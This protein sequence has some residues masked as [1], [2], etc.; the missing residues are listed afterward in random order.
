MP[1]KKGVAA[2]RRTLDYLNSGRL[3][4]KDKVKIC[5]I[6]YHETEPESDGLRRFVFWHLAQIK[7]KN[8]NVQCVQL[9]NIVKSPFIT[10]HTVEDD[11]KINSIMVNCY[12]K[13]EDEILDY[14][15]KLVGKTVAEIAQETQTNQANFGEGCSRFCIC[16]VDGQVA[17]PRWKPLPLFMRGKYTM[18]KKEELEEYRKNKSDEEALKDYWNSRF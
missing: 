9:K 11:E 18:Y 6:N 10:F 16:Q 2:Y 4:L 17:C 8:P 1:F 13:K 3:V 7:Y 14:C 15:I 5:A 12:K